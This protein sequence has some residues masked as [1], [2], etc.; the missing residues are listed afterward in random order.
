MRDDWKYYE[1]GARRI[2]RFVEE[3]KDLLPQDAFE[4]IAEKFLASLD[5]AL[6]IILGT[7]AES[8]SIF[9]ASTVMTLLYMMFWLCDPIYIGE[10]V[11]A[12]FQQ[13]IL[14]KSLASFLYAFCVWLLL[15]FLN[16]D[17]AIVFGVITFFCN[18]VPEIG[19]FFAMLFPLPVLIFD[20]R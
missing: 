17:L 11:A 19:P 4:G 10:K 20:G 14:L 16:V 13:Y 18:F 9:A 3:K 12:V 1:R 7:V 6:K 5:E 15:H 2:Q 8:V